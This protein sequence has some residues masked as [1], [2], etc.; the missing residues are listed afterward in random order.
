MQPADDFQTMPGGLYFWQ[1]Y[2]PSVKTDLCSSALVIDGALYFID[3]VPLAKEPLQM[4]VSDAVPA[5]IILTNGNHARAA[6]VYRK[7]FAVPV[8]AHREAQGG[9]DVEVDHWLEDGASIAS[10]LT[11]IHLPGAANGEMAIH[12]AAG[13]GVMLV[14]DALINIEPHGFTFLPD[15]YCAD[16]RRMKQSLRKLLQ[17]S[18]EAMTFAHG[19]PVV[20]GAKQRLAQ[21][22]A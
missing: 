18:F 14:G 13:G 11:V 15:K 1:G 5:G 2:D 12:S 3:P 21:L 22:L 9:F 20:S 10:A 19:L 6:A 17:F 16:A 4:L 8:F 7:K